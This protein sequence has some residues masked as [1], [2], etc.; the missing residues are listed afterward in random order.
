MTRSFA[1]VEL[2][3][4]VCAGFAS[5][6]P[7]ARAARIDFAASDLGG[8]SVV[9]TDLGPGALAFDPAFPAFA[10]MR[11][12]IVV[13]DGDVGAAL[14]WNALVDN[15]TGEL[16]RAFSIELDGATFDTVGSAVANASVV[17]GIDVG[18]TTARVRF[19][20]A[21]EAAGL[22]LGAATGTG[23][24]W[25]IALGQLTVG[26][27][28]AIV[29]TPHVVPEPASLALLALGVGGLAGMSGGRRRR[30]AH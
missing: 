20:D 25:R 13:E 11:L 2:V 26:D 15:L 1:V 18:A 21:G 24:D 30:R 29:M 4:L 22:D 5:S 10:P 23:E 17:A 28:F 16:W 12:A 8:G 27:S 14:A 9:E 6:S 19:G 3:A 7:A